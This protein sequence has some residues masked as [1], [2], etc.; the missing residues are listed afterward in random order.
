V[1]HQKGCCCGRGYLD[2]TIVRRGGRICRDCAKRTTS[3]NRALEWETPTKE[4]G[5]G[6][7]GDG[8][9]GMLAREIALCG[10]TASHLVPAVIDTGESS[11]CDGGGEGSQ[12]G[13]EGEEPHSVWLRWMERE[14][15][16][17]GEGQGQAKGERSQGER[18]EIAVVL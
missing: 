4:L 17:R 11:A 14:R 7:I 10:D 3:H 13:D 8:A 2:A 12:G 16:E 9:R 1:E 15:G 18:N 5:V 6:Q